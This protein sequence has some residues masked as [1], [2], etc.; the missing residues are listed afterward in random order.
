MFYQCYTDPFEADIQHTN[1]P[2]VW[3][4]PAETENSCY[5]VEF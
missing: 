5:R 2:G 3:I 1:K 4:T